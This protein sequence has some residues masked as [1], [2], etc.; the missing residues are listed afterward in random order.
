MKSANRLHLALFVIAFISGYAYIATIAFKPYEFSYLLKAT[1]V[2]LLALIAFLKMGKAD[3]NTL[4]KPQTV[5][6]V[7]AMLASAS[8]DIFLDF[9]R[10]VYL[11]QA[12]GSFLITQIAY[13][14]LFFPLRD[15]TTQRRCLMPPLVVMTLVLLYQFSLTAGALFIP[16]V[17]YCLVLLAMAFC[18][19]LVKD[20]IWINVGGLAFLIADALIGVNRFIVSFEYSTTIIVSIYISAQLMI[21]WGLLF[22]RYR[23]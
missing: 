5:A 15:L 2:L 3:P 4:T 18:A 1:P 23:E 14:Y 19:L 11:K 16:V 9:D 10:S 8:G 20:N 7:L 17:I 6:L 13:V 12:L 22:H 21:G